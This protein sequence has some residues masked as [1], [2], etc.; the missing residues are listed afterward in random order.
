[1]PGLKWES[2]DDFYVFHVL[3]PDSRVISVS[4]L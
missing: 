1:M 4:I 3:I 2:F